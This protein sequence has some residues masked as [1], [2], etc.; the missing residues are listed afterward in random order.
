MV[1]VPDDDEFDDGKLVEGASDRTGS[2]GI[3]VVLSLSS[4]RTRLGGGRKPE[5]TKK[6]K[7]RAHAHAD[8]ELEARI[9]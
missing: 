5:T 8:F 1:V 2:S 3:V 6:K 7:K 9:E 4:L